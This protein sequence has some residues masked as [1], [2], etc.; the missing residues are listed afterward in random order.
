MMNAAALFPPFTE[1]RQ[2]IG[3][4][5]IEMS[6]A[7]DVLNHFEP[8]KLVKLVKPAAVRHVSTTF[9]AENKKYAII[10]FTGKRGETCEFTMKV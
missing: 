7:Q 10:P 1:K 6:K 9:L 8:N 2:K 4:V 5:V 3:F